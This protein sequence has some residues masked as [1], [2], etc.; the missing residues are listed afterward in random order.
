MNGKNLKLAIIE[1]TVV[2]KSKRIIALILLVYMVTIFPEV[3]VE[4]HG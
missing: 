2:C 3:D 4:L 1:P